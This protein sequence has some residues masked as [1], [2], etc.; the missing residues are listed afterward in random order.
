MGLQGK[1][2]DRESVGDVEA[3]IYRTNVSSPI[4]PKVVPLPKEKSTVSGAQK[5]KSAIIEAIDKDISSH[6]EAD[7][8]SYH[9]KRPTRSKTAAASKKKS[10]VPVESA[11]PKPKVPVERARPKP[12]A[13]VEPARPKPQADTSRPKPQAQVTE[14]E[15][16]RLEADLVESTV[17]ASK[18]PKSK[19]SVQEH[20]KQKSKMEKSTDQGNIDIEPSERL[21]KEKRKAD[22]FDEPIV[23]KPFTKRPSIDLMFPPTKKIALE[24]PTVV[25]TPQTHR[26]ALP[27]G[28]GSIPK[29][30][31]SALKRAMAKSSKIDHRLDLGKEVARGKTY[32]P[33]DLHAATVHEDTP[34]SQADAKLSVI[35]KRLVN[36]IWIFLSA[37]SLIV[38]L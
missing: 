30:H 21:V 23:P 37:K 19:K 4:K 7:D 24:H 16:S 6:H 38:V 18:P 11:R 32:S 15:S 22:E 17:K 31:S 8:E 36:V 28:E 3:H 34:T 29:Y 5:R 14:I 9:E 25:Q 27:L 26:A 1:T 10:E 12:K 35:L 13:H 2:S 33:L 20:E